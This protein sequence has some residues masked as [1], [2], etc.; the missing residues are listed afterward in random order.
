MATLEITSKRNDEDR[1]ELTVSIS[2]DEVQRHFNA[3][4]KKAGKV[5]IPGFRPGKAPRRV[6]ENH[7]GGKEY[8]QA[9]ATDELV[10]ENLP[11]AID[12][13]GYVPLDKPEI[14]ELDLVEEGREYSY[15]MSFTVR[16]ML[17]LSSYESAQIELPSE[18]PT[19]EE[20][21]QQI[22][23]MLE[24]YVD[25]EDVT[26]RPVEEGDFL[27]LEMEAVCDG[28]RL[29][30][31]SGDA[32]PYQL[33]SGGMPASFDERLFGMGVNETREFD[34]TFSPDEESLIDDNK[35]THVVVTVKEIKAKVKPELTDAWVK[36]KIEFD[37]IDEFKSRIADSIRTQKQSELTSLKEQLIVEELIARLQGEPTDLLVTQTE[38][39]IYRDFFTSLQRNNQ[40]LDSFLTSAGITPD[41]FRENIR[42]QAIE[43]ASQALA[44]DALARHLELEIAE[45][46]IRAEFESSGAEDP[47]ELY[48]QWKENGRLSEIRES[49]LRVKAMRYFNENA[50]IF[51]P[52][53]KP[54][55]VKEPQKTKQS[56]AAKPESDASAIE[57]ATVEKK[58]AEKPE[59]DASAT[60][61]IASAK[62]A[63]T[64]KAAAKK[65]AAKKP[66]KAT[67]QEPEHEKVATKRKPA[68][69]KTDNKS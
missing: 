30:G 50:E 15:T 61:T 62:P 22:D 23:T 31:L 53:E 44:L 41:E 19:P 56:R 7:Y 47:N 51:E 26:D 27:T 6:L 40:T 25:F 48:L 24:Y 55:A 5:R 3:V 28:E 14:A 67:N 52:G 9:Q 17:E 21:E 49:L 1:I 20:I 29:D 59:S 39:G 63:A 8:F 38:Q 43:V 10:N 68:A 16:P 13:E 11:L 45:E 42:K 64:D 35:P 37:G 46:E 54:V 69:K 18:E 58:A 65:S 12:A 33:G 57:K 60:E 34:F 4:Y 32:I 66:A 2:A 36:E